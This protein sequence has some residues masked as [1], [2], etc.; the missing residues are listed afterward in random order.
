MTI[1]QIMLFIQMKVKGE[2]QKGGCQFYENTLNH[3][4]L[5]LLSY[6]NLHLGGL[7]GQQ[8]KRMCLDNCTVYW[9]GDLKM[10]STFCLYMYL[11]TQIIF[12]VGV[13]EKC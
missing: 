10:P 7:L 13:R 5:V 1:H 4:T 2:C 9:C 6:E 11:L 12:Q 8:I 3:G